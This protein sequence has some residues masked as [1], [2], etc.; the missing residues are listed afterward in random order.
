MTNSFNEFAKAK[1]FMVIGSNMTEAHPVAATYLKNAVA[2]GAQLIVVD[3]RRHALADHAALHVP[4]RV[5]S[6][7]A[8]LNSVM[9]VLI[10]ENLYDQKFVASC[11]V[12][13]EKLKEKV[14]AYP[15]KKAAAICG[16][17][18]DLIRGWPGVSAPSN[19]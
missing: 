15:P 16:I 19:P 10:E 5:G 18:A 14:Q 1:M 13:F 12:D 8:F 11:T 3:P 2:A 4:L 9:Q 17:E 6:D 7:I